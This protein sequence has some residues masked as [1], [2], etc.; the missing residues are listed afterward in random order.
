MQIGQSLKNPLKNTS[1]GYFDSMCDQFN[2]CNVTNVNAAKNLSVHESGYI[3]LGVVGTQQA[4][5]TGFNI[6]LPKPTR[7]AWYKFIL[8]AP[9][10]ANNSN[11]AITIKSTSDGSS[12]AN[13][14]IGNIRGHGNDEGA[15]VVSAVDIITFVHNVATAGDMAEV[16]SDGTNWFADIVYDV[17][18]AVTLA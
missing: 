18:S 16:W 14:I 5:G 6:N 8:A 15:N 9:S 2:F 17:D 13:L 7:G 3:V 12:A 11:A 1:G 10:I 4:V